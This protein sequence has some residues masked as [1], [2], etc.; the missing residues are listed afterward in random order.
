MA[1]LSANALTVLERR[2][3]LKDEQGQ[4]IEDGDALF[5]RV[6]HAVALAE[7]AYQPDR[8]QENK[9]KFVG[10]LGS[11]DFLP[12]SPTLANAGARTGQLSACFVLP[13]PDDLGGIFDSVKH[14]ALIHK[15]GG[16]TGFSFS[17]LRHCNDRVK[18]TG[19]QSSGP[20]SFM[21]VF[22]TATE[23]I[24]QGGMRRGANMGILRCDHP[25]I[26]SF[27]RYK[28]D[29]SKLT[30]FNISVAVTDAFMLA[31]AEDLTYPLINP[32]TGLITDYLDAG[33]VWNELIARAWNTGEPG[34]IFIDRMNRWNPIPWLG[35]YEATNPCGEQSLIPYESCNLGSINLEKFVI[36][37]EAGQLVV[38]WDRLRAQTETAVLFMDDVIDVNRY[39]LPEIDTVSR[40]TRKLGIGVMGF[41][42]ML[43]ALGIR[44]GSEESQILAEKIM[45][46]IDYHSKLAS[47]QLAVERGPF[48][49]RIGHEAESNAYFL[50]L[51][52]DR[53]QQPNKHPDCDYLALYCLIEAHGIR[54]S[55]TTT[56]APTGTISIV[57]DATSGCEPVFGLVFKRLQAERHMLDVDKAFVYALQTARYPDGSVG[58]SE[59]A[60]ET[61][62]N[63]LAEPDSH[64]SLNPYCIQRLYEQMNDECVEVV[65][66]LA[67]VFVTAHE[68]SPTQHV[69]IQASFQKF[70]DSSISKTINFSSEASVAD[71]A[72]AY[73]L[74]WQTGCKG[75]TIYRDGSRAFQPLATSRPAETPAETP[76]PVDQDKSCP[77]TDCSG[78]LEPYPGCRKGKCNQCSYIPCA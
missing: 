33:T 20:L 57:A 17:R 23:S 27:I 50:R 42:R 44:Y 8:F 56:V 29:L 49:A 14:A 39:P 41:A 76:E 13:V 10:L 78:Q 61:I 24:K 4:L 62:T 70:N 73:N 38:D 31:V 32:R 69:L 12:N 1:Q 64:G 45:S 59:K 65:Q 40:A 43:F 53:D 35:L 26:L 22:N 68:I 48:P 15:T 71:V 55:N 47:V 77:E 16:G 2:Y 74:A 30:N 18:G 36:V 19:G 5:D 25:D 7:L 63:T 11:L 54:N 75:V 46:F 6:A 72:T 3:F 51:C 58:F 28:E 66:A 67:Q 21:D 9:D 60:I 34:V 37:D 52:Q